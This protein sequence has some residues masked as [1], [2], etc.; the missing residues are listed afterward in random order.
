[1]ILEKCSPIDT[2][3]LCLLELAPAMLLAVSPRHWYCSA[4]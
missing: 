2:F 4:L 1:M 3:L